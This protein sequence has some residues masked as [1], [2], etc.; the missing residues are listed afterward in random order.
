M[1]IIDDRLS[2]T[3]DPGTYLAPDGYSRSLLEDKEL[4]PIFVGDPSLG[5]MYQDWHAT[6]TAGS[7]IILLTPAI[8]GPPVEA[9]PIPVFGITEL[10]FAFEQT[11]NTAVTY[12]TGGLVYL[13][14]FDTNLAAYDTI[15]IPDAVSSMLTLDD[16]RTM[17]EASSDI[18]LWYSKLELDGTYSVHYRQQRERYI[19]ERVLQATGLP[20]YPWKLGMNDGLRVQ[21]SMRS[22]AA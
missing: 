20:R 1:A 8:T 2:T 14:Y 12:R 9:L 6:Y 3:P 19:T 16:K 22:S 21:L 5:S 4:G 17:Q 15:V 11:G 13:Y 10:S 18:L 7:G